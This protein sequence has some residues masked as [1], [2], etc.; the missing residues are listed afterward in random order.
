ML[1][2]DCRNSTL[3][4]FD[5]MNM[6]LFSLILL[7]TNIAMKEK[8]YVKFLGW[9]C[10]AVSVSVFAALLNIIVSEIIKTF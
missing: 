4:V 5:S 1:N 6:G 2:F 9:I 7:V 10:V 8:F 3:K